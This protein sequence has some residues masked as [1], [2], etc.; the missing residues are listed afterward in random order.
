MGAK[1]NEYPFFKPLNHK[2][3]FKEPLELHIR[4][5]VDNSSLLWQDKQKAKDLEID[6]QLVKTS[7]CNY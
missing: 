1:A 6:L 4:S 3:G 7:S 2:F 5:M